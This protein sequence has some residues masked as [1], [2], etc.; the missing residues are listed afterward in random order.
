ME[1]LRQKFETGLFPE[2][3]QLS[4][5]ELLAA[6][7]EQFSE[8]VLD[9]A[10]SLKKP[11]PEQKLTYHHVQRLNYLLSSLIKLESSVV[12]GRVFFFL[13]S[14]IDNNLVADL[15]DG[16]IKLLRQNMDIAQI[17]FNERL[18]ERD[19]SVVPLSNG[20]LYRPNLQDGNHSVVPNK[21][22]DKFLHLML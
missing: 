4:E 19:L 3:E 13:K 9:V 2:E 22:S 16:E 1:I 10:W 17:I 8:F 18:E 14:A 15:P 11:Y 6:R 12:L 5:C 21:V 7:Q 20:S